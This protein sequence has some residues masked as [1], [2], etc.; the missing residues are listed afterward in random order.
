VVEDV[1]TIAQTDLERVYREEGPRLWR[2]VL[3]YSGDR[4]L[5]SDA[6]AETFAQALARASAIHDARLWVWRT[7]FRIAAGELKDRRRRIGVDTSD[8]SY[9]L[10]GDR[11]ELVSAL[12]KLSPNQRAALVLHYY[13][14]RSTKQ[15]AVILGMSAATVRVHLSQGRKRLRSILEE[16]PDA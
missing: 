6:V 11:S 9:E 15:I 8:G 2:A 7:A 5:A 1:V 4:E 16:E 13:A 12:S 10:G 14:D 3:A